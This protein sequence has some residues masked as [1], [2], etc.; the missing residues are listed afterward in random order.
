MPIKL[1]K[2]FQRRKSSGNAL[3]ELPNPPEP[4][5]R[6]FERPQGRQSFDGGNSYKNYKRM[7]LARPLSEGQFGEDHLF[8]DGRTRDNPSNRYVAGLQ[9]GRRTMLKRQQ[10]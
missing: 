3:E 6:V 4:S 5:F 1:P 2:G 8:V 9:F 7:S 10:G